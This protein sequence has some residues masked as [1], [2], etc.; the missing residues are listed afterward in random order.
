MELAVDGIRCAGCMHA[1]E[2][3]LSR[4]AGLL[5]ARVNL[6]LKRVTV[7]WREGALRPES[8]VE[9]LAALGFKAYP[10]LPGGQEDADSREERRLLR[11]S[12]SP[13]SPP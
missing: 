13:A 11:C 4:E 9:R 6:A 2:D 7:E 5:T 12:A 3:G 8:V 1:I 10:F